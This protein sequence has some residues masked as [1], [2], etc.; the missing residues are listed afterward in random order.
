MGV[1]EEVGG[2]EDGSD[3]SFMCMWDECGMTT[4]DSREMVRHVHFHAFH[5]RIKAGGEQLL[6]DEGTNC[7]VPDPT[8]LLKC[9]E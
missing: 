6:A 4:V 5:A 3:P 9:R 8:Q 1:A 7:M 2:G